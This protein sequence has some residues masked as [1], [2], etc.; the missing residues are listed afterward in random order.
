MRRETSK[1]LIYCST[2]FL[3]CLGEEDVF[4]SMPTGGGKSLCY[5]L[6]AVLLDGVTIVI[7]PLLALIDNQLEQLHSRGINAEAL[8]S[9]TPASERK[10]IISSLKSVQ[11]TGIKLL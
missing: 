1:S 11:P 2:R 10:K 5:Q 3:Y 6:P 8:N 7:S 4:I 9:K